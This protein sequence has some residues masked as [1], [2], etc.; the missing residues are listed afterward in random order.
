MSTP[1]LPALKKIFLS[2]IL[3]T[4]ILGLLAWFVFSDKTSISFMLGCVIHIIPSFVFAKVFLKYTGARAAK[5]VVSRF[6]AGEALKLL[7][8]IVLFMLV[9]QWKPLEP[10]PLFFGFIF[11]Q[12]IYWII[13]SQ[14]K[15]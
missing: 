14:S 11:M 13:L 6:Y 9:L 7:L 8:T 10:L 5:K 12:L 2:Q 3:L 15:S 4:I 1:F